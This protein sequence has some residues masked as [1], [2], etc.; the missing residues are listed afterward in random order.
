MPYGANMEVF[1]MAASSIT[2]KGA[3]AAQPNKGPGNNRSAYVPVVTPHVIVAGDVTISSGTTATVTLP[4]ALLHA[5]ADYVVMVTTNGAT[6]AYVSA[7]TD[8]ADGKMVSFQVTGGNGHTVSWMIVNKGYG[9]E[10]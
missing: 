10:V 1:L 9:L 2:G 3:G 6:L 5:A 4:K 8:D 7:K